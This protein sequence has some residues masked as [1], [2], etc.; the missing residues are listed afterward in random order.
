MGGRLRPNMQLVTSLVSSLE[1]LGRLI[2]ETDQSREEEVE[3]PKADIRRVWSGRVG[4]GRWS[5]ETALG[6]HP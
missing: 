1:G 4:T 5:Q 6:D 3:V 2:G